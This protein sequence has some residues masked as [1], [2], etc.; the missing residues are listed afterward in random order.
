MLSGPTLYGTYWP[1]LLA[2]VPPEVTLTSGFVREALFGY[3]DGTNKVILGVG[4]G[5]TR[6]VSHSRLNSTMASL[7]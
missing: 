4:C 5:G 6:S 7:Y 2:G 3:G 1:Q